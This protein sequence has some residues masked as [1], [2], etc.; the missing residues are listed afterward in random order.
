MQKN[1]LY[2]RVSRSCHDY[3][4]LKPPLPYRSSC[5]STMMPDFQKVKFLNRNWVLCFRPLS[6]VLSVVY[7][8]RCLITHFLQKWMPSPD[9]RL[10][11]GG[12]CIAQGHTCFSPSCPKF[13]SR[14]SQKFSLDVAEIYLS[15]CLEQG[16]EAWGCQSNPSSISY[17][18]ASTTKLYIILYLTAYWADYLEFTSSNFSTFPCVRIKFTVQFQIYAT[19]MKF[20]QT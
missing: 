18:Q 10:S 20:N 19:P 6:V 4:P 11:G 2:D 3:L 8:C 5:C 7:L 12:G 9:Q 13:D 15:H 1:S 16:I 17:W 14:H